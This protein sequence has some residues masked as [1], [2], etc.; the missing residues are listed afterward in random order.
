[1]KFKG[2]LVDH[3]MLA[4]GE[5]RL[6][7]QTRDDLRGLYDQLSTDEVSTDVKK[8]RKP[9]SLDANAYFHLIVNRIAA[10]IG[11]SDEDVK[12]ELVVKYGT[13]ET[14]EDGSPYGAMLPESADIDKIYPYTR[15]YKTMEMNG[16]TYRCYL[17]Y[18]HTHDMNS[19]EMS[20]L[21]DGTV[22]E[23]KALGIETM[24]PDQI[25]ELEG[26]TPP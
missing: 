25:R 15:C 11:S 12:R 4:N 24:T 22:S 13:V 1:M 16:K 14:D 18:K 26:L 3:V 21:I 9:R 6:T 20:H 19:A 8:Y 17:L 7:I 2:R 10:I 5:Q 23:A